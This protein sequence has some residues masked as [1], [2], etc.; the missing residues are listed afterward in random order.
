MRFYSTYSSVF[1]YSVLKF[2]YNL[3]FGLDE[4]SVCHLSFVQAKETVGCYMLEFIV[5][6]PI[7]GALYCRPHSAKVCLTW[8]AQL[9]W[10]CSSVSLLH[11]MYTFLPILLLSICTRWCQNA[12]WGWHPGHIPRCSCQE[13]FATDS[14]KEPVDLVLHFLL[15]NRIWTTQA[16]HNLVWKPPLS[17]WAFCRHYTMSHLF[18]LGDLEQRAFSIH[19]FTAVWKVSWSSRGMPRLTGGWNNMNNKFS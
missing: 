16:L 17:Q 6:E 14:Q 11:S 4:T 19:V 18:S 15:K 3:N 5:W 9:S 12:A 7:T 8:L 1:P 13:M 10:F 2:T